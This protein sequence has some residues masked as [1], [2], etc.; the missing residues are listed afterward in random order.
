MKNMSFTRIVF[1]LLALMLVVKLALVFSLADVFFYGEELEKGTAAKAMIDGIDVPHY[2][3]A[4][5]YYEGGGFAISHLTAAAFLAVGQNILAHKLVSLCLNVA[6][7]LAGITFLR[8]NWGTTAGVVFGLLYSFGPGAFQK[9]SLLNLGIH[10]E[11]SLFLLLVCHFGARLLCDDALNRRT[12]IAFGLAAGFGTFFNFGILP[13]AVFWIVVLFLLRR[14]L[15]TQANNLTLGWS[16]LLGATPLIL[17]WLA[18]GNEVFNIHGTSLVGGGAEGAEAAPGN[19]AALQSF[20]ASLF[21]NLSALQLSI[22]ALWIA[23]PAI[24]FKVSAKFGS[25]KAHKLYSILCAYALFFAVLYAAS[26][27]VVSEAFHHFLFQRL[28]PFWI[29]A[30]CLISATLGTM[31]TAAR[32]SAENSKLSAAA[33]ALLGLFLVAG[34]GAT[35]QAIAAGGG[36]GLSEN[37]SLLTA[38]KGYTY[39]EYF[40]KFIPHL[41]GEHE[42]QLHTLLEFDEPARPLLYADAA[43]ALYRRSSLPPETILAAFRNADRENY[44]EFMPGLGPYLHYRVNG[45]MKLALQSAVQMPNQLRGVFIEALGR[46]GLY[47]NPPPEKLVLEIED[48][49]SNPPPSPYYR[50][51]GYRTFLAYRLDPTGAAEFIGSLP[52]PQQ[53]L[54]R[55]G[56]LAARSVHH[57]A[58]DPAQ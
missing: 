20:V 39:I 44:L 42:E 3:L 29:V 40:A 51:I 52:E 27:F 31:F 48:W 37:L 4:Y 46:R 19:L 32:A 5:H 14:S 1:A 15:F 12:V 10:Y 18:V 2:A 36:R 17:M 33:R 7:L 23:V 49:A 28:T 22:L 57:F 24:G 34:I 21:E 55:E 11:S 26:P 54:V 45:R 38:T 43:A 50:G 41:P 13:L 35:A 6:I 9:L 56:Y 47:L 25:P 58:P 8:R 30:L 53:S 16:L